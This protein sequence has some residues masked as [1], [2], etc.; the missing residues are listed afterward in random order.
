MKVVAQQCF[1]C[2]KAYDKIYTNIEFLVPPYKIKQPM[3]SQIKKYIIKKIS[4]KKNQ[5]NWTNQNRRMNKLS[6]DFI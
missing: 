4:I 2:G 6:I 1:E 5:M 3:I